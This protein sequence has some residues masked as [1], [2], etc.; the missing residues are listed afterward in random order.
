M[1]WFI[2]GFAVTF[3]SLIVTTE[4]IERRR[5]NVLR[6]DNGRNCQHRILPERRDS[7]TGTVYRHKNP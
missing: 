3:T 6:I 2:A 4:V 1:N 5:E 7:G